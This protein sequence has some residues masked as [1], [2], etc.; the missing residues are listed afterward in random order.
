M[1]L[2][3]HE[4]SPLSSPAGQSWQA[5]KQMRRLELF[6][7][8]VCACAARCC[9]ASVAAATADNAIAVQ[10]AAPPLYGNNAAR[11]TAAIN[12]LIPVA[13]TI[14][15]VSEFTGNDVRRGAGLPMESKH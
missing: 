10:P 8:C 6:F 11:R 14:A 3:C 5:G 9:S 15:I 2:P 4:V 13:K 12:R 7:D 1:I